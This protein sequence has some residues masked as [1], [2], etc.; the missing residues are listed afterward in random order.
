MAY[1]KSGG[2]GPDESGLSLRTMVELVKNE[3]KDFRR[4]MQ[5]AL[6]NTMSLKFYLK[7]E[8]LFISLGIGHTVPLYSNG[9]TNRSA[10]HARPNN[11]NI[12]FANKFRNFTNLLL[13]DKT[14]AYFARPNLI[15]IQSLFIV[16]SVSYLYR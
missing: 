5:K 10:A 8:V 7:S 9:G 4:I 3:P 14:D 16:Y 2:Y 12:I 13:F 15:R 6:S 11:K 1:S